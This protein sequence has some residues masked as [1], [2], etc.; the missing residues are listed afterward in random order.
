MWHKKK[1]N[2]ER[3]RSKCRENLASLTD[4]EHLVLNRYSKP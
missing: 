3:N 2:G 4:T 1:S